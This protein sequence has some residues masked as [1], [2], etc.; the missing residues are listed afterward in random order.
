MERIL[1]IGDVHGCNNIL[2][3][4]LFDRIKIAHSDTIYFIGDYIDRGMFSKEVIDTIITLRE[5]GYSI[6]TLRGNHEQMMMDSVLSEEHFDHWYINGG[7][8]TLTSFDIDS[9]TEMPEK[10]KQFFYDTELYINTP[11]YIFV[12]AG[13]N[14]EREN[15]FEDTEAM[16]WIRGFQSTQPALKNQLLVH[17]HTPKPLN[18]ILRQKGNCI[19]IDGGCVYTGQ[20]VYGNLVAVSLPERKFIVEPN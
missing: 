14:F 6:H 12:H 7:D 4:M 19:N 11:D 13:L 5:K 20:N 15:I 9:F 16:L 18:Y 1:A 3:R 2:N 10:Y 17:G 8:A